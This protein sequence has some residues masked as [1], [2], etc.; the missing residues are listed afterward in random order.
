MSQRTLSGWLAVSQRAPTSPPVSSSATNTSFSVPRAG[1]QP[2]RASVARGHRLGGDLRLHVQRAA[3]PQVA[4][5][6]VA[7]PR[8]VLPVRR[9]GQHRV[10]VAEEAQ[11]R[12]VVVAGER[13]HE[14]GA[15]GRRAEDLGLEAGAASG[16]RRGTRSPA[17]SLP[18]G[19]TVLKRIRRWRTAVVCVLEVVGRSCVR[20]TTSSDARRAADDLDARTGAGRRRR[21][22]RPARYRAEDLRRSRRSRI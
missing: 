7:G 5:G 8:V 21:R 3:T 12:A 20:Q 22:D 6:D 9:I 11:R 10:D 1:R 4:V 16:S 19:L 15:L 18:G 17:R 14:V 2:S 13:G